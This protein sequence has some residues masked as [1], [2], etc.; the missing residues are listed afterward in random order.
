[1]GAGAGYEENLGHGV[2]SVGWT[3]LSLGS[4]ISSSVGCDVALE[5]VSETQLTRGVRRNGQPMCLVG[6]CV[7][8]CSCCLS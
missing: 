8:R 6:V 2:Y 1:M 4:D 5:M 3:P 7:G